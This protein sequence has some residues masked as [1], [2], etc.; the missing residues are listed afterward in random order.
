MPNDV[1]RGLRR[2]LEPWF[3]AYALVGLLV[4]ALVPILVPLT[5]ASHG[6][7]SVA[8][9]ISA[10]FLGQ[11]TAPLIGAVADRRGL[12]RVVFLSSYPVMA[13]AAV[14]FGLSG[15]MGWW[16]V[17]ALVAGA[18]AGAAQ[19][20]GSVFIVEGHPPSEW[21][22]RIGWFRLTF[23]LGQVAGLAIGAVFAD[24]RIDIGWFVGG[25]VILLGVVFGRW[26]LPK[27]TSV[28]DRADLS[29]RVGLPRLAALHAGL[30][31]PRLPRS[32]RG[33]FGR[34]L[35]TWFLAM[36]AVQTVLNVM[37]LVMKHAFDVTPSH[38]ATYY[39]VGSGVGA[40][41]YPVCGALAKR[42]GSGRIL[43]L[44]LWINLGAFVIM[45]VMWGLGELFH[46]P[47]GHVVGPLALLVVAIG[48]PVD[49]VGG[50]MMAAELTKDSE[51]SAMGLFN[52]AVAAGAIVGAIVPS[53]L[54][55]SSG[56][57]SLPVLAAVVMV[58]AIVVGAGVL[59][60]AD[61]P[62]GGLSRAQ[63]PAAP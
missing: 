60:P 41:L 43:A 27:L 1:T 50:T 23:G 31:H 8:I 18:A 24:G 52:S 56:Y 28:G 14:G 20:T 9:V 47:G 12:Q 42:H 33:R 10:F 34:F 5:V 22:M 17:A 40:L 3:V 15:S 51:G 4:N 7:T 21:D 38:T 49:Y 2:W 29:R 16:I 26:R 36:I 55:G 48:Y 19:T 35:V 37:P 25:A 63:P 11:M 58:A 30:A 53:F 6:P 62:R 57:G 13:V 32:L 44:G 45:G 54:A 61:R 46:V 39:L 59:S